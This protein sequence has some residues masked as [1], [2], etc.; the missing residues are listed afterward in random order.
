MQCFHIHI[1]IYVYVYILILR[2]KKEPLYKVCSLTK[3]GGGGVKYI[4]KLNKEKV[5]GIYFPFPVFPFNVHFQKKQHCPRPRRLL[6][7]AISPPAP[8]GLGDHRKGKI[9]MASHE[10]VGTRGDLASFSSS[11]RLLLVVVTGSKKRGTK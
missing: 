2:P 7:V 10:R 1:Y 3:H 6:L 5:G 11:C 9:N 8:R 4:L